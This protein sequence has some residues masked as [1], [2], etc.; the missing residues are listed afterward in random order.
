MKSP[1]V[2]IIQPPPVIGIDA[3]RSTVPQRSGTE[4]YS[5]QIIRALINTPSRYT[6]KLYFRDK[7][8]PSLFPRA[9]FVDSVV[10]PSPLAWTHLRLS[11]ELA[12]NPPNMVFVPS[13]VRPI[14][15]KVPSV[16]TVHDLGFIHHPNMHP[17]LQLAYL[18]WSTS[19]NITKANHLLADSEATKIEIIK[20]YNTDPAKI[21]VVYPGF[22]SKPY[23]TPIEIGHIP[24]LPEPYIL[25]VGTLHPR[26]G[27]S[28]LINALAELR[29][30]NIKINLVCAGRDGWMMSPIRSQIE[31][32]D[33][34]HRVYFLGFVSQEHLPLI[35][36]R[37]K[38]TVL[39]SL[40][41]GFGYTTLESMAS[42]TPVICTSAGSLPEVV[43]D[44]ALT[45]PP[46]DSSSLTDAI[47]TVLTNESVRQDL[48]SRGLKHCTR[49][50]WSST[51]NQTLAIIEQVLSAKNNHVSI[52][53]K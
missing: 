27:L 8:I 3:S 53:P 21:T 29:D 7:P 43:G 26:K 36:S 33:L 19:H 25:Y 52:K 24:N 17:P 51:A 40:Y 10:I 30:H 41:E 45:V 22:D 14:Y 20:H 39:P 34:V 50:P 47:N 32:L 13:H 28:D 5:L 6:W 15:C 18:R 2:N 46:G 12:L 42:G 23:N 1:G 35:Y 4:N 11:I 37:A 49:F 48:I 44:A 38:L 9:G 31:K 16:V